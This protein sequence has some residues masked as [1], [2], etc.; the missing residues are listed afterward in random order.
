[1][2]YNGR[3]DETNLANFFLC[4]LRQDRLVQILEESIVREENMT[5]LMQVAKLAKRCLQ[6]KGCDRPSMK[7]VAMELEGLR[8]GERETRI[9]VENYAEE[10]YSS[11]E[12]F[13]EN[14]GCSTIVQK[15]DTI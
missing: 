13:L 1:M 10:E 3:E 6:L 4:M 7:E 12:R 5:Q 9:Q 2:S 15:F 11:P 8:L 14:H